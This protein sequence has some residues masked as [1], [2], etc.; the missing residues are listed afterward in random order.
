MTSPD[1][2]V[3]AG[4]LATLKG[5]AKSSQAS[6]KSLAKI[7]QPPAEYDR[8]N[9]STEGIKWQNELVGEKLTQTAGK[10]Y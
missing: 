3:S 7:I 2:H 10:Q 5:S 4:L 9:D 6:N 8:I 1:S